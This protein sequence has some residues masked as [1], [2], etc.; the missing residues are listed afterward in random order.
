MIII[1]FTRKV[2]LFWTFKKIKVVYNIFLI[3]HDARIVIID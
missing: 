3:R 2:F 1:K